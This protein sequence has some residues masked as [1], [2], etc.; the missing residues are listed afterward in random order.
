MPTLAVQRLDLRAVIAVFVALALAAAAVVLSNDADAQTS[1]PY[2]L[3]IGGVTAEAEAYAF[4]AG[5]EATAGDTAFDVDRYQAG[6][7]TARPGRV[8]VLLDDPALTELYRFTTTRELLPSAT[9][10][11]AGLTIT[12]VNVSVDE[13]EVEGQ[14]EDELQLALRYEALTVDEGTGGS[15]WD[16]RRSLTC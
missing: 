12:M 11:G 1:A 15:C 3:S 9:I 2:T 6:A 16:F 4:S 8:Y 10:T 13:F 14:G 5:I 7:A